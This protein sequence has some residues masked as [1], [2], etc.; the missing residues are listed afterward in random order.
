MP[1]HRIAMAAPLSDGAVEYTDGSP[2]TLEQYSKDV[3]AFL[4]W[5]AEPYMIKRKETGLRVMLYVA[6]MTVIFYLNYRLV[7]RRVKG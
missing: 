6:L 1:G 3:S 4:T 5:T 7:K 2:K